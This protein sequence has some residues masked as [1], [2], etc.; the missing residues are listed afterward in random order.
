MCDPSLPSPT[1]SQRAGFTLIELLVVI[2]IIAILIALL[3]P[4]VQKV[5]EAAAR[6]QCSNNLKQLGLAVHAYHDT[7]KRIPPNAITIN[8]N[9]ATDQ[10]VPGPNTWTWIARILPYIEQGTLATTYN[11]PGGTLGA[12]QP[13]L[14]TIIP[15][16]I[17]P[18]AIEKNTPAVANDWANT[19]WNAVTM[20]LTNYRGVSGYNWGMNGS[21][22]FTTA[23]AVADPDATYGQ[24]G[25]DMGN[26]IFYRSDGN[27]VLTLPKITDGTSNTL[28]IGE[29]THSYDQH[30]GGW[31]MPNY[32]NGTCAIPLNYNDPPP[33]TYGNWPNRYS[34]RSFHS[35]GGN[36]CLADG[37]VRFVS[38]GINI[39]IYRNACSIRGGETATLD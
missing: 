21:S 35:G 8:Y 10:S 39:N 6:A 34:F 22:T 16:L 26:G 30:C 12:A 14:A 28:M 33:A 7:Q 38:Q 31:A 2:A 17:C 32:V 11:I 19:G 9:W 1:S 25:L 24:R 15:V 4:A 23:F 3:V 20:G 27:R 18:S 5:R 36:F 37:S 13:G 29:S